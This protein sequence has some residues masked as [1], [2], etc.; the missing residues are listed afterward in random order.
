VTDFF[1]PFAASGLE[2]AMEV[3][4][5]QGINLARAAAKTA[6]LRHYI[7]STLTNGS[8]ITDGKYNVPYFAAKNKIDDF[9][10]RDA[11]LLAKT[12]FFWITF[13]GNNF[14]YPMFTPNLIVSSL[15]AAGSSSIVL[16]TY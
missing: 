5:A 3:E 13:Y 10:K 1:E 2:R 11:D 9:I 14:Q 7:W 6:T 15:M 8:R 4:E 16:N 12:T